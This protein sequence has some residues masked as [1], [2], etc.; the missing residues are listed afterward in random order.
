MTPRPQVKILNGSDI[1][2][3]ITDQYLKT[4]FTDV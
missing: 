3:N 4:N 2:E 1:S